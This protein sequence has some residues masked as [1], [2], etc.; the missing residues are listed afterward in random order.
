[1]RNKY[2]HLL[3]N[4]RLLLAGAEVKEL[5]KVGLKERGSGM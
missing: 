2:K 1:M 5:M 4:P 3:E